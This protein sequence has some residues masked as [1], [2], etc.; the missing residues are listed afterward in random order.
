MH[1]KVSG[2]AFAGPPAR[3]V[4]R[5]QCAAQA[6]RD[7][8]FRRVTRREPLL[9]GGKSR[10]SNPYQRKVDEVAPD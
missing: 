8:S 5:S 6:L 1:I 7:P 4:C 10:R 2:A 3:I 9:S